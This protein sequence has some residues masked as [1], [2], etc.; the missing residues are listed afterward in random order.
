MLA[1]GAIAVSTA[2]AVPP[3]RK[4]KCATAERRQHM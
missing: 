4:P 2:D 1:T 3:V